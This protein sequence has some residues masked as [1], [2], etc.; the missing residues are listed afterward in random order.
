MS[1]PDWI[2]VDWGT[3]NLRAWGLS[4][5]GTVIKTAQSDKG[6]GKLTRDEFDSVLNELVGAWVDR[7]TPVIAC[8]MV[9]SRQGWVEAPY[10][11]VPCPALPQGF[12]RPT[13]SNPNLNVMI[14]PGI[15]Q[16]VPADV[17][18]G[19]ETQVAGFLALNKNWDGVVCLPGTHTKWALVSADEMVSFQTAM[20]GDL[21][22][23]ISGHTVLRHSMGD[24]WDDEGFDI[25]L[26]DGLSHPEKLAGR[27]FSLR[28]EGLLNGLPNDTARARLSG[29]LIGLELAAAKPYW[30]GQQV[31][32][33]GEGSLSRLYIH[34]LATQSVAATQVNADRATLAGLT[35]AYR[36]WKENECPA[37]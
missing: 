34:A 2:A 33:I 35:A 14:I 24:G 32:V 29:F 20:T 27:M 30:L 7:P 5:S 17:M 4:D 1:M 13:V 21:F 25:G 36:H 26:E 37:H 23:A 15:K 9:G 8:G 18:R 3:S 31:A 12:A 19:E 28:A 22:A 6:M 11:S 16:A 10:A